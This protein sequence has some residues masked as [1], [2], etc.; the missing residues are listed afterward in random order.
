[1]SISQ[2]FL[3]YSD[4]MYVSIHRRPSTEGAANAILFP[5]S[6]HQ[7]CTYVP[8]M[9]SK[10]PGKCQ[11][12]RVIAFSAREK[13]A[14]EGGDT[15]ITTCAFSDTQACPLLELPALCSLIGDPLSEL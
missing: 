14:S 13:Q 9:K 3:T 6:T 4:M 12:H 5:L 15:T 11:N 7:E 8:Q 1:M 10:M 2:G